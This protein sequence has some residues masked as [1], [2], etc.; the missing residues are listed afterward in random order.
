MELATLDIR[1]LTTALWPAVEE[2]FGTMQGASR[3]WC[4]YFR[5]GPKYRQRDAEQ[6]RDD[7]RSIVDAGPPPGLVALDG[8]IAVGW[9][10]ITPRESIPAIERMGK[11]QRVDD[12][13]VWAI[14]C[15]VI[16]KEYRRR[17]VG[18]TLV[19]AAVDRARKA[20]APAVEAYPVDRA[21]SPSTSSTGYATTFEKAGF[22]E[23]ARRTP[24]RPIMRLDLA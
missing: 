23:V 5:V 7:L 9:C 3:C 14:S 11:L 24:E 17:G 22:R 13:P 19:A 18:T 8:D 2:L 4:M 15:F 20:G 6:N 16:R 10:Q 12:V 1:P 21:V